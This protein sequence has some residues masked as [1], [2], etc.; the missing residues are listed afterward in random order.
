[1]GI[2]KRHNVKKKTKVEQLPRLSWG[3]NRLDAWWEKHQ[4]KQKVNGGWGSTE[5]VLYPEFEDFSDMPCDFSENEMPF[6][7]AFSVIGEFG[8]G[9]NVANPPSGYTYAQYLAAIAITLLK[10]DDDEPPFL[11]TTIPVQTGAIKL[12]KDL[13]FEQ[14]AVVKNPCTKNLV[15]LWLFE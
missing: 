12:L 10:E 6:C 15:T 8:N 4:T 5:T 13:G 7:C 2:I 14:L 3:L 1:M 9:L 11:A